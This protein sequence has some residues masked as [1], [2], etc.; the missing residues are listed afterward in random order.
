MKRKYLYLSVLC[1]FGIM[2]FL[3]GCKKEK[4]V[5]ETDC[6]YY[7]NQE[8]N[9]IVGEPYSLTATDLEEQVLEY[10][11]Q[12]KSTPKS[13][14]CKSVL[15]SDM[16]ISSKDI[17]MSVNGQ[18]SIY[19]PKE[20]DELT[21]IKEVL[22]RAAIVKTLCQIEQV[23]FVNFY[24]DGSPLDSPNGTT[25]G[26]MYPEEFLDYAKDG[27]K[28]CQQINLKLYF[29]TENGE[30]LMIENVS[31]EYTGDISLEEFIVKELMKGPSDE[32]LRA[33][34]PGNSTLLKI[35]EQD[36]I[37]Y[38]DFDEKFL[39]KPEKISDSVAIYSVVNS[40]LEMSNIDKVQ[41]TI[42][43]K[44]V[45]KYQSIPLEKPLERNLNI[46]KQM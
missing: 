2:F 25:I 23:K 13:K 4:K 43:G 42:N 30:K 40:L 9:K 7:I 5:A 44:Y 11:Q 1:L 16:E 38:V 46:M 27:K 10:I 35:N 12:L 21:G 18:L 19:F 34:I 33:T 26:D 22:A 29:A 31:S 14:S 3:A 17:R 6:V 32:K 15:P 8:E 24:V 41:I 39:E 45:K 28:Y 36:G 37:C 20:Y